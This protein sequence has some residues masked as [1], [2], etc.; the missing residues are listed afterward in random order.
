MA[1]SAYVP[2]EDSLKLAE[3][4]AGVSV[5]LGIGPTRI[6][7]SAEGGV[8]IC[9]YKGQRYGDIECLNTGEILAC[10][11]DGTGNPK[12]WEVDGQDYAPAIREIQAWLA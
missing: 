6:V 4:I 8:G 5:R 11:S 12:V 1:G 9:Y 3:Q 2:S 7:P 10:T